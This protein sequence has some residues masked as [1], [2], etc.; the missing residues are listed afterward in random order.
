MP[1]P[2]LERARAE[3]TPLIDGNTVSFVWAGS[4]PAQ[5]ISDFAG[6]GDHFA[7]DMERVSPGIWKFTLDLPSD[8]YIEYIFL[9]EGDRVLDPFNRRKTDNGFGKYNSYFY[10]PRAGH[11]RLIRRKKA[12]PQGKIRALDVSGGWFLPRGERRVYFY[13]PPVDAPC[14]LV[15]VWD[16]QEYL[17]RAYLPQ[18]IDNLVAQG[19]IQPVAL[20]MVE[21]NSPTRAAEYM[22]SEATLAFL[23]RHLLPVARHHLNLVDPV[24]HP[25]SYG[26]LGASAGGV[27]ALYTALRM[28]QV[29]GRVLAQSGGYTVFNYRT[30]IWD[31]VLWADPRPYKI[32][33]CA[34]R[35]DQLLDCNRE[36]AA[37]LE[38]RGFNFR[39]VEYTA[40]HNYPAW[41]DHLPPGLEFIF[42]L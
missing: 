34:G 15:V 41:R 3:G 38:E 16:G 1:E 5:I 42:G 10:M 35:Y 20:A 37:L 12:V 32:W 31:M 39:Y 19:R 23:E 30:V 40:G 29:F 2:L 11:T 21:N 24:Q 4:R 8:A 26:V 17:R 25:G 9:V 18:I 7:V 36:M 13:Q 14:P 6:W 28:P 33:M 22:C 27:M